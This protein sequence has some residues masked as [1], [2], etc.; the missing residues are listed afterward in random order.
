MK[1][2]KNKAAAYKICWIIKKCIKKEP[3]TNRALK[4]EIW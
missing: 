2:I 3:P 4:I 1:I